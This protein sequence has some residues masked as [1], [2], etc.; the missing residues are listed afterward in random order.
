MK[1]LIYIRLRRVSGTPLFT[2]ASK[3][4]VAPL[5]PFGPEVPAMTSTDTTH[6]HP[7]AERR[8]LDAIELQSI[9]DPEGSAGTMSRVMANR[10]YIRGLGANQFAGHEQDVALE[11]LEHANRMIQNPPM[12]FGTASP[13]SGVYDK[14]SGLVEEIIPHKPPAPQQ[15]VRVVKP[16]GTVE[17]AGGAGHGQ[18][19]YVYDPSRSGP[20]G[21]GMNPTQ[22]RAMDDATALIANALKNR[23][24]MEDKDIAEIRGM[25]AGMLIAAGL[26]PDVILPQITE[27]LK[28]QAQPST[29][30]TT[31]KGDTFQQLKSDFG[32]E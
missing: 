19:A 27:R 24:E 7:S 32:I 21:Q 8:T 31:I 26:D 9:V 1:R 16:D 12:P 5:T 14:R 30:V 15:G 2:A 25:A 28:Q 6:R 3:E 20:G 10:D 11:R 4:G 17:W 18:Q 22:Q 13:G 29:A 23:A